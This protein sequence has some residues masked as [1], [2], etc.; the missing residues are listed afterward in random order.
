MLLVASFIGPSDLLAQDLPAF[1]E[2][3]AKTRNQLQELGPVAAV[4]ASSSSGLMAKS[5]PEVA[6]NQMCLSQGN[7]FEGHY[8]FDFG[9]KYG[10]VKSQYEDV[11]PKFV[12]AI[13]YLHHASKSRKFDAQ[14]REFIDREIAMLTLDCNHEKIDCSQDGKYYLAAKG[15]YRP[16]VILGDIYAH[17]AVDCSITDPFA[18]ETSLRKKTDFRK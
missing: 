3:D 17:Y 15:G 10:F 4:G 11:K 1:C 6:A 7:G 18:A 5:F 9:T 13:D 8:L 12:I 2:T 16:V 14:T